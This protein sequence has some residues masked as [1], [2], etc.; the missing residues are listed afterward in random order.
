MEFDNIA[1]G[2]CSYCEPDYNKNY[3]V[4]Y[5]SGCLWQTEDGIPTTCYP[6]GTVSVAVVVSGG[7]YA[8]AVTYAFG[9]GIEHL[10]FR[11]PLE[12]EKP[13]C[14]T[15]TDLSLPLVS[16][17]MFVCSSASATCVLTAIP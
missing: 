10:F 5:Q 6:S 2:S 14:D 8:L 4:P 12:V 9:I 17:L 7:L 15:L 13:D 3:I 11:S 1:D 16:D